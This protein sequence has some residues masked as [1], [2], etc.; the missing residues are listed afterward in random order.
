MNYKEL[1]NEIIEWIKDWFKS[2]NAQGTAVIGISGGKDSTIVAKLCLEALGEDKVIGVSMPDEGQDDEDAKA[3]AEAIGLK[4]LITVPIQAGVRAVA[5]NSVASC[6]LG[7]LCKDGKIETV[8]DFKK[9]VSRS[10]QNLPPRIRMAALYYISQLFNGRVANTCN[11]SEDWLGYATIYGD[12]AGDFG[13]LENLTVTEIRGVGDALGIPRK[14]VWKIPDDGLPN[15]APDEEKFGFSYEVL[16]KYIRTGECKDP[17]V[18]AKIDRMHEASQFKRDLLHI[19]AY[20]LW[21]GKIDEDLK[22]D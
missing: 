16:D 21:S 13:P 6:I 8:D 5:N 1:A 10:E 18:K 3:V 9:F 11:L 22:F 7:N 20:S 12:A 15:S 19:P 17:E 14:W 4:H 2:T